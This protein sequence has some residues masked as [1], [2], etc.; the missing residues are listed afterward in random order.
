MLA[1]V[2]AL[3][4]E[5]GA[6]DWVDKNLSAKNALGDDDAKLVER[7]FAKNSR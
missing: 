4:S 1:D 3:G 7:V 2:G 6:A 5:D